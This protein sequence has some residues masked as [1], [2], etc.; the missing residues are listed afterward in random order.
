MRV[1][2]ATAIALLLFALAA[3]TQETKTEA[4]VTDEPLS[5]DAVA[6]YQT[7]LRE[8]SNG[9]GERVNVA[10]ITEPLEDSA[11]ACAGFKIASS[12]AVHKLKESVLPTS[13]FVLVDAEAQRKQIEAN[14]PQQLVRRAIDE[15]Q[16]VTESEVESSV[17]GAFASGLFTFSE[18]A[19]SRDG[20]RAV[21]SYSFVCGRLCGHGD[22]Y[23]LRKV[24]AKWK[25]AKTCGG[26]MS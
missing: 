7:V 24:G 22:T 12:N 9:S 10:E 8:Y 21:V 17:Q 3:I 14:D 6:V 20:R 26:W 5:K 13:E 19:F 25:I 1:L 16:P 2:C 11:G 15:H 18:I 23:L 4:R